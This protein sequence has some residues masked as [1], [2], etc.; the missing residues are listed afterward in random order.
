MRRSSGFTLIEILV[1]IAIIAAILGGISLMIQAAA[2]ARTKTACQGRL[3]SL[4]AC[5]ER[6]RAP[7]KLNMYPPSRAESLIGPGTSGHVGKLLG[8]GNDVNC[9]IESVYVAMRL[10][11]V[12]ES[13]DGFDEE[14]SIENLDGDKAAAAVPDLKNVELYE[15]LDPWGNP[16]VYFNSRDYKDVKKLERYMLGNGTE[17][18]VAP[19]TLA[20]GEFARPTSFQLF[21]LGPDGL[22]GTE[23]DLHF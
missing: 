5:I 21:S 6:L 3:A 18:K 23:D 7:D 13:A 4:G 8:A 17:I 14:G 22:P 19:K 1:V 11:G 2:R 10:K 12:N 9:G 16:F 20:N 15:Y